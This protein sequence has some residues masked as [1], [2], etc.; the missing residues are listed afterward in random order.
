MP[1]PC[2]TLERFSECNCFA[3]SA[4]MGTYG[5]RDLAANNMGHSAL[6]PTC[7][8]AA[9][10]RGHHL[11][12]LAPA[13]LAAYHR[14]GYARPGSCGAL[15]GRQGCSAAAVSGQPGKYKTLG[16][17]ASGSAAGAGAEVMASRQGIIYAPGRCC[18]GKVMQHGQ[19]LLH[20]SHLQMWA[21]LTTALERF[22]CL[23]ACT[24]WRVAIKHLVY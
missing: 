13:C 14:R 11:T 2:H 19:S 8:V 23:A 16:S 20:G 6:S 12:L 18:S 5:E 9:Y 10:T 3:L 21:R 7:N 4:A 15:A 22:C 17:L 1:S 24:S